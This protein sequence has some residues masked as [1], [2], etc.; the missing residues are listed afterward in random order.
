[1]V[2]CFTM[3]PWEVKRKIY[4]HRDINY[5]L[6]NGHK[7]ANWWNRSCNWQLPTY[8]IY[9]YLKVPNRFDVVVTLL[10]DIRTI[11]AV[12]NRAH[13]FNNP[14][15][16]TQWETG[17]I[18]RCAI[19]VDKTV[20]TVNTAEL[21]KQHLVASSP[22]FFNE[23][24]IYALKINSFLRYSAISPNFALWWKLTLKKI[25]ARSKWI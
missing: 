22:A 8:A 14:I 12:N 21:V 7:I 24:G 15:R 1:M 2:T 5:T 19:S 18:V 9:S 17:R 25:E 3:R 4:S 23:K 13:E 10:G 6:K 20:F 11:F 16:Q